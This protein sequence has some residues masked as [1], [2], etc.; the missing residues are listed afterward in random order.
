MSVEVAARRVE[1]ISAPSVLGL[2]PRGVER[3]GA[4]LLDRGLADRL[5]APVTIV[6]PPPY[7]AGKDPNTGITNSDAIRTYADD[8][9]AEVTA[10]WGRGA[11]PLVLGGDCSIVLGPLLA[12]RRAGRFGLAFVDGHADFAHPST[13]PTGEAASM[14]LALATGRGPGPFYPVGGHTRLVEDADVAVVGYRVHDDGTDTCAGEH[15]ADTAITALDLADIRSEGIEATVERVLGVVTGPGLGGFWVHVD[16]DVLH[17][18]DMPAVDYRY[19]DGLRW[20][21]LEV[22][23]G[24][25]V[26]AGAAGLDLT[27]FNPDLDPSGGLAQRLVD[28]VVS[29]LEP[30]G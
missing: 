7:Q 30:L 2:F 23:L 18:D 27:V 8:L 10:A 29:S 17:D 11:F 6:E 28:L 25:L 26:H 19:P 1:V 15:V 5:G 4:A 14:D 13:E 9:A 20:A 22:V 3:L 16:V 24:R 21:G 12:G